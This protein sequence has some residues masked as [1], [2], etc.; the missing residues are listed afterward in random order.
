M[1]GS[2]GALAPR[3]GAALAGIEETGMREF[4]G[5]VVGSEAYAL[6]LSSVREIT[7]VPPVTEVP[8]GPRDVLGIISLRGQVTTLVD[9]RRRLSMPESPLT[10]RTRVLLVERHDETLGLLVDRVLQVY[11]LREDE[12][13]LASVLGSDASSYV[14]GIGRPGGGAKGARGEGRDI[15]GTDGQILILLDPMALLKQHGGG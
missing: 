12:V 11:R 1:S 7:R 13:E 4:L 5:F 6:P 3:H 2:K 8:R 15:A 9:L 14:M 10:P